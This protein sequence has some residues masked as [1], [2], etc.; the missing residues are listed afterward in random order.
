M[1]SEYRDPM[2]EEGIH[3]IIL[4]NRCGNRCTL[5]AHDDRLE[6]EL[7]YKPNAFRRKDFAARNFSTRDN[8]STLFR[9]VC[10]PD[11]SAA[12]CSHFA[13]DPFH[14][15]IDLATEVGAKTS[16]HL[17]NICDEN[18]FAISAPA[19][20]L[21]RIAC[22]GHAEL[23]DGL[24]LEKRH[25]RGEDFIAFIA[26][27]GIEQNRYRQLDDG[28]HVVQIYE[29]DVLLIG[30]EE[31]ETQVN[32]VL[33]KLGQLTQEQLIQ[34]NE[35]GLAAD[36]RYARQI[37]S[38]PDWQRVADINQ[39]VV[40]SGID[41]GGACFGAINRIYHL[42][43]V[44]DGSM[45]CCHSALAGDPEPLRI[46]A[47]FLFANPSRVRGGEDGSI[48]EQF[49]QMVG[50]R[51]SKAEDDGL[52]Y[53][54]WTLFTHFQ[55]TGDDRLLQ[56]EALPLMLRGID[57]QLD[58][59]WD[60][61]LGLMVSDTLG[62]DPLP[63]SPTYG[64]DVVNGSLLKRHRHHGQEAGVAP[65]HAA[66]TLYHQVNTYNVLRIAGILLA[67][68]PDIDPGVA[69]RYND[70][71]ERLQQSL[72]S[73]F[74]AKDGQIYSLFVRYADGSEEWRPWSMGC[75]HWE[76]GW[77]VS[78]GPFYPVPGLQLTSARLALATWASHKP[79]GYC[80]W[81]VL[82]RS[83][84]EHGASSQ[85]VADYL[86]D[87][88]EDAQHCP[89]KYPMAGALTEY[90]RAVESWRGLPFSAGSFRNVCASQLLQAQAQGLAVRGGLMLQR[91]EDFRYRLSRIDVR[92]EGEAEGVSAYTINGVCIRGSLLIP[93]ERFQ[94]GANQI[95]IQRG[96]A[97]VRC[98][99]HGSD[100]RLVRYHEDEQGCQAHFHSA[101]PMQ[102]RIQ[103]IDAG[104][105]Q[106]RD[107]Q[108]QCIQT[109]R[110][111]L[112]DTD[113]SILHLPAGRV[114][115]QLGWMPA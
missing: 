92:A 77:A 97:T 80:P 19:P 12:S 108:G 46:W 67:E 78:Q 23:R 14:T 98:R 74:V 9:S 114:T 110:E 38:D 18:V 31:S 66:A 71:A 2:V 8:F 27:P 73:Q 63:S 13:Y 32:R 24:L 45:T 100:A 37:H 39:R 35:Q 109:K 90:H 89:K 72:T 107:D 82:T 50:T 112:A 88:I 75:D 104:S 11:W 106:L 4:Q 79:Y 59:C 1:Q 17:V 57:E 68:R 58:R 62:E 48:R 93:E 29:N 105:V 44:R 69:T 40:W 61:E 20:L 25:E 91:I 60:E 64:Y 76:H 30:G 54:A 81:N 94:A 52:F 53:A 42:I 15:R 95:V 65:V 51:W 21:L 34:R 113:L 49:G 84:F 6:L 86:H 111:D 103:Q 47:P 102:V 10:L 33:R 41:A 16:L 83:A 22:H 70:L 101:V 115:L 99:I 85:A 28:S 3:N 96:E 7:V 5:L 43:W 26:F 87:E 56:S 55:S 36:L